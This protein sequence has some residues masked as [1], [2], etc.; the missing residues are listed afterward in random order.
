MNARSKR[1]STLTLCFA[2]VVALG[3]GC[4]G[5]HHRAS[6]TNDSQAATTDRGLPTA[7]V[8]RQTAPTVDYSLPDLCNLGAV[9]RAA[10]EKWRPPSDRGFLRSVA[11]DLRADARAER[12]PGAFESGCSEIVIPVHK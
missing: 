4:G 10:R 2:A 7:P 5:G 9:E 6:S 8:T 3:A 12:R 11:R 1:V